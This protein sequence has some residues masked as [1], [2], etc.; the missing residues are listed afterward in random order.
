[1]QDHWKRRTQPPR[2]TSPVHQ[3]GSGPQVRGTLVLILEWLQAHTRAQCEAAPRRTHGPVGIQ[4][5]YQ[6]SI[7]RRS[8][9]RSQTRAPVHPS[10]PRAPQPG[11]KKVAPT[12]CKSGHQR[13]RRGLRGTKKCPHPQ[14]VEGRT[15]LVSVSCELLTRVL[16]L[17][18]F[19][20]APSRT[21]AVCRSSR[22]AALRR[23]QAR[24]SCRSCHRHSAARRGHWAGSPNC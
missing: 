11:T 22:P 8:N 2:F 17:P 4:P 18:R 13:M 23:A 1:M 14:L 7:N 3:P 19:N 21:A 10:R 20:R 24:C 5:T 9:A 16:N 12:S 15:L 6:R